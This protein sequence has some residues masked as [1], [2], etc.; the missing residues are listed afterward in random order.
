MGVKILVPVFDGDVIFTC[1]LRI[2]AH[3]THG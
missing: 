2:M 3:H 1:K